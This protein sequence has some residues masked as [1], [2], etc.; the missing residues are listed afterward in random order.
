[1]ESSVV[2]KKRNSSIELLKIIA[3]IMIIFSHSV[4]Y[5]TVHDFIGKVNLGLATTDI[6]SIILII[7]KYLGQIGNAIFIIS[8]AYFLIDNDKVKGKKV[9]NIIL[10]AMGI[11][12]LICVILKIFGNFTITNKETIKSFFPITFQNNWFITCYLCFYV[13]HPVLNLFIN[14]LEK[15][16]LLQIDII[17]CIYL[18]LN[19]VK[20]SLFYYNDLIAFI[21]IYFIVAY[22][23][24]YMKNY[25]KNTKINRIILLVASLL[26]IA[27]IVIINLLGVEF[28]ITSS[29]M[30]FCIYINPL[31]MI[32][33][34]SMFN[35][36]ANKKEYKNKA[37][38]YISSITLIIY[39]VH[40]NYL[41]REYVR[42]AYFSYI[43]TKYGTISI[44]YCILLALIMAIVSV[45]IG[46][47]YKETIQKI[48][49][50]LGE[51]VYKIIQNIFEK[52]TNSCIKGE[53]KDG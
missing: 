1:M 44:I 2:R 33:A 16:R 46:M 20:Q 40:D 37:I 30:R 14:K 9:F 25:T 6:N 31:V 35:L 47:V 29:L 19:T 50:K 3:I 53:I 15:K 45:I 51:K 48:I 26:L 42:T 12:I 43:Y 18:T 4:P 22:I 49:H 36:F 38:N 5:G 11:S 41:I 27:F 10:D 39:M 21:S 52:V 32:I 7:M 24:K 23:K 28:N 34:I 17:L 13:V 8:S